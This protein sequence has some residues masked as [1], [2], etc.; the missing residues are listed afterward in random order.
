MRLLV[1]R[2]PVR[3]MGDDR[4]VLEFALQREEVRRG[5]QLIIFPEGTRRPVDAPPNYKSGVGQIYVDCGV[6]CLP[7]ALNAGL[8]WPR[9]RSAA[10]ATASMICA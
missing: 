10:S 4:L 1:G 9:S 2:D 7:V 8:F 3:D 6:P 5:R